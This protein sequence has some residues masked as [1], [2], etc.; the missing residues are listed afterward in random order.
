MERGNMAIR[1]TEREGP[2]PAGASPPRRNL[3]LWFPFFHVLIDLGIWKSLS[4]KATK[5]Y[6]VICKFADF[7]TGECYPSLRTLARLSGLG[8]TRIREAVDEL[9]EKGLL[10]CE[11]G[12]RQRSNRYRVIQLGV[13]E[14]GTR[15]SLPG[16][17]LSAAATPHG[18][19][20]GTPV[21]PPG[22]Q[23]YTQVTITKVT[24]TKND[25]DAAGGF[26]EGAGDLVQVIAGELGLK[27]TGVGE[28]E[29]LL[30][31]YGVEWV[32]ESFK[33]A[34]RRGKLTLR[35]MEGILKNWRRM[36][37]TAPKLKSEADRDV[38]TELQVQADQD[39]HRILQRA[40]DGRKAFERVEQAIAGLPDRER[41]LL[42]AQA[43]IECEQ[44]R[45][46]WIVRDAMITSKIR[47]KVAERFG[48]EGL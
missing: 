6:P 37:K 43:E 39:R 48:I 40:E 34:V 32:G 16:T 28:L 9:V 46:P 19:A 27:K 13:P 15:G 30:G 47:K 42:R 18:S 45:I 21:G 4:K 14:T 38:R 20:A 10:T 11:K 1:K 41:S 12:D 2:P 7:E 35:Y 29:E 8:L 33:E 31:E 36:G 26:L 44:E 5:L 3:G 22:A 17:P 23:N 24:S 25:G